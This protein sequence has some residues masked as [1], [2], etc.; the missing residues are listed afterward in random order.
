MEHAVRKLNALGYSASDIQSIG[1]TNQRETVL[2]WDRLTGQPIYPAIIW[3]DGRT[4]E[5]VQKLA[6]SHEKGKLALQHICGLPLTTY[7]SAVKLRWLLDNIPE[8]AEA[9]EQGRLQFGTL[10]TWLIYVSIIK[11]KK[12]VFFLSVI[13][14]KK[15]VYPKLFFFFYNLFWD[16]QKS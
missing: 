11:K 10:D 7:F 5:T 1:I 16:W 6:S 4:A 13:S 15:N 2:V 3:S 8:V 14:L 12:I 9:K